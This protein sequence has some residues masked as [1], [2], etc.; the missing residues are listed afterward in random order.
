MKSIFKVCII[1][2]LLTYQS[3]VST[4]EESRSSFNIVNSISE[5]KIDEVLLNNDIVVLGI[6][7]RFEP[8]IE[9]LNGPNDN[10]PDM[11]LEYYLKSL[12]T[13]D[14]SV[15]KSHNLNDKAKIYVYA[16]EPENDHLYAREYAYLLHQKHNN[17]DYMFDYSIP[18]IMVFKNGEFIKSFSYNRKPGIEGIELKDLVLELSIESNK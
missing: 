4:R 16:T 17:K 18:V 3:C 10:T 12:T 11:M 15:I 5:E 1:L 7:D 9:S 8:Q 13:M 2:T 14:N 6:I